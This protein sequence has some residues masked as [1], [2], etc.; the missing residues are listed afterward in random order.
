LELGLNKVAGVSCL[1]TNKHI[2]VFF[3]VDDIVVIYKKEHEHII[4]DFQAKLFKSYKMRYLGEIKWFLKIKIIRDRHLN[5]LWLSQDSYIDKLAAKFKIEAADTKQPKIL[6]PIKE[7]TAHT[8]KAS[9]QDIYAYQQLVG[10]ISFAA[11]ITRPDIACASSKLAEHLTNPSTRHIQLAK[12][13][14]EYLVATK[15]FAIEFDSSMVNARK[16][17]TTAQPDTTI[18]QASSD[19]SFA[20]DPDTRRSSQGYVFQ[21]FN[22]VIDWKASKQRTITTSSTEAE[23]LALSHA[24]KETQ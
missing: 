8:N 11:L 14:I 13:V 22:G 15:W 23:L 16:I 19:A 17:L 21:L 5:K 1:Y 3:F 12:R 6:L 10:S 20:D 4:E 24:A 9:A 2:I 7:L 18:F